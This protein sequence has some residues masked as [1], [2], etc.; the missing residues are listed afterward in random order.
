[1]NHLES[2]G[3]Y[4]KPTSE[5]KHEYSKIG[6]HDEISSASLLSK[7]KS[8]VEGNPNLE[9]KIDNPYK[10]TCAKNKKSF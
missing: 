4:K 9:V 1:M 6:Y 2:I 10:A 7:N 3:V 5:E 8:L